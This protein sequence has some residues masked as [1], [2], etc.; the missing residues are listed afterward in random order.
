MVRPSVATERLVA[1][2]YRHQ[3]INATNY[4]AK[5][6]GSEPEADALLTADISVTRQCYDALMRHASPDQP[7]FAARAAAHSLAGRPSARSC[8]A[9]GL[10]QRRKGFPGEP[11]CGRGR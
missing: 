6:P 11:A 8:T 5:A 4:K 1:D 10:E 3:D 9:A 7:L 2:A